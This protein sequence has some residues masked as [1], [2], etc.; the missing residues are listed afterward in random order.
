MPY[1]AVSIALNIVLFLVAYALQSDKLTDMSYALTFMVI[2][3][4]AFAL[5]NQTVYNSVL[6]GM[7]MAWAARLG[8]FLV[9]R[10]FT[11]GKDARFDSMR[12]SFTG[13]GSFWLLQGVTVGVSMIAAVLA[14]HS[15]HS[16]LNSLAYAGLAIFAVGLAVEA[17]AD[18]QKMAFKST[19][20]NQGRWI[21]TGLWRY[22][23]HPNYFGEILVWAG[24]YIYALQSFGV[25][26]ALVALVSPVFISLLLIFVSGV[27]ILEKSADKKWGD[28]KKY[29]AYKKHTSLLVPLPPRVGR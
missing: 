2:A 9:Y 24:V 27:P 26:A 15:G 1:I 21:D 10:V 20:K 19:K 16:Q 17:V 12:S 7:I 29:Q 5:N 11:V 3:A 4:A 14:F 18:Y 22:S 23:R 6:L 28:N 25:Y 8:G 13:F